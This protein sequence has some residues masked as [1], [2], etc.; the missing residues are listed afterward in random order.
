MYTHAHGIH[1][2]IHAR[3]HTRRQTRGWRVR[4]KGGAPTP[5]A[6]LALSLLSP[7]PFSLPLSVSLFLRGGSSL[8]ALSHTLSPSFSLSP[9]NSSLPPQLFSPP[10]PLA[11][12]FVGALSSSTLLFCEKGW[13]LER[14]RG[15]P[16]RET[17]T[18]GKG[19]LGYGSETDRRARGWRRHTTN[20]GGQDER[21]VQRTEPSQLQDN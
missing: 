4:K 14:K 3:T 8:F 15:P 10:Q 1:T 19:G 18:D 21:W 12:A 9:S 13:L 16:E 6:S 5:A 20:G 17:E 7:R 2:H 11:S